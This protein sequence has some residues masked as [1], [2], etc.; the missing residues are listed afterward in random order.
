MQNFLD[1]V[2]AVLQLMK[3]PDSPCKDVKPY[4]TCYVSLFKYLLEE[5]IPFSMD[6]AMSWLESKTNDLSPTSYANYRKALFRLEHYLMFGSIKTPFCHSDDFL[7]C[8]SGMSESF[9]RLTYELQEHLDT[10]QNP[11]YYHTY[12]VEIKAF[13]RF[14]TAH[15]MTEPEAITIGLIL[16]YWDEYCLQLESLTH[17]QKAVRAMTALMKY[18]NKRGDVPACYQMVLPKENAEKLKKMR[19]SKTGNASH[20]SMPLES[21]FEGFF[22][23]LDDWNYKESS[24][25]LYQSDLI[26]YCM[27]LE[28]N[29][30]EHTSETVRSWGA[31]LPEYPNQ[32][33]QNCTVSARRIHTIR[34]FDAYLRRDL[35]GNIVQ[36]RPL[37]I[38]SLPEWSRVIISGFLESRRQDGVTEKTI[39][40]CRAAGNNFFQY[41][42]KNG[43]CDPRD[44]TP[45][46]VKR[47]Q[48]QDYHS[49][50]ES[51]NAYMIKLRQLLNYMADQELVPATLVY[52]VST[53]CA[54]RRVIVDVLSDEAV[55]KIYEYRSKTST[56]LELRDIAIVM[57]GLRMGIRGIDILNLKISDFDWKNKTVSFIQRK[58]RKAITLPVSVE[59]GNSVYKYITRGRPRSADAGNGYVFIRHQAPYIPFSNS[60]TACKNALRRILADSGIDLKPGQG[61]HMTRKTFATRMLRADNRVDD[62]ANALG[63]ARK[64]TTETY[65]ERDEKNM[66]LC[67]LTFGGVL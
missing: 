44:I 38:D 49:T 23:T 22:N 21:Q 26:W 53:S 33:K 2:T 37:A 58:T 16:D 51:K 20:P 34:L 17:R 30:L 12:S 42:E 45:E 63:H 4:H 62:I 19:L 15:G 5:G 25:S 31:A 11:C 27:F 46:I 61:F 43:I 1:T 47:F 66:R 24:K 41:L 50:P 52:A 54:P 18:L 67:P 39:V 13:F 6:A 8:R 56:P 48:F 60:A 3:E 36:N 65:L 29:H 32:K 55:E 57:L 28:L 10:A 9:Y 7:F 64:E 14:A 59:V 40:N 35:S